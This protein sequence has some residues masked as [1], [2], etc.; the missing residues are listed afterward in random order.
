LMIYWKNNYN[1]F[2]SEKE[3]YSLVNYL[4]KKEFHDNGVR[5]IE[6]NNWLAQLY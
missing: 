2:F 3:F 1:S 4:K 5:L 6:F